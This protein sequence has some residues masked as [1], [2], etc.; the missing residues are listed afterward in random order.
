M[1]HSPLQKT[2]QLELL[3]VRGAVAATLKERLVLTM[4]ITIFSVFCSHEIREVLCMAFLGQLGLKGI[5]DL[6]L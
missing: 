3:L 2:L 5:G 6:L 4:K 1:T